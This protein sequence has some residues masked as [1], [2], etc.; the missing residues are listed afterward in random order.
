MAAAKEERE[1]KAP[2]HRKRQH[3]S[4]LL[5]P[6]KGP[7]MYYLFSAVLVD[8]FGI[9][10][11]LYVSELIGCT[12]CII[13]V[14]HQNYIPCRSFLPI[15]RVGRGSASEE[16]M[17]IGWLSEILKAKSTEDLQSGKKFRYVHVCLA[18]LY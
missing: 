13:R 3:S 7:G 8:Y 2:S 11:N 18:R 4:E 14:L 12:Y 10:V 9:R 5:Q 1:K 16:G 6:P 15:A 17:Y